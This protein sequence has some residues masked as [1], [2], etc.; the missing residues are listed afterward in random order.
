MV[1]VKVDDEIRKTVLR[2][3]RDLAIWTIGL[4]GSERKIE[5]IEVVLALGWKY[6]LTQ[7]VKEKLT[8]WMK[9]IAGVRG[10][11]AKKA[12]EE[13]KSAY[14]RDEPDTLWGQIAGYLPEGNVETMVRGYGSKS[15]K[16]RKLLVAGWARQWERQRLLDCVCKAEREGREGW[17]WLLREWMAGERGPDE[18]QWM[19]GVSEVTRRG[20][21]MYKYGRTAQRWECRCEDREEEAETHILWECSRLEEARAI[22]N[23]KI[24]TWHRS[25]K[26]KWARATAKERT[27]WVISEGEKVGKSGQRK[28]KSD[29]LH[30]LQAVQ[31]KMCA[32]VMC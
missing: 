22:F 25:L 24:A 9:T 7:V 28:M 16:E 29:V 23:E 20:I 17:A 18:T 30:L 27:R 19:R 14:E 10:D 15:E 31:A 21:L 26:R 12:M 11:M 4:Q 8:V 13:S 2:T 6:V 3:Q 5:T 1:L 32:D